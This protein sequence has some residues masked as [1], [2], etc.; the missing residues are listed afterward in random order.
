MKRFLSTTGI[1]IALVLLLTVSSCKNDP[2]VKI[3]LIE[4]ILIDDNSDQ[5][6]GLVSEHTDSMGME[7]NSSKQ[8]VSIVGYYSEYTLFYDGSG[9]LAKVEVIE[10]RL[11][12]V[13]YDYYIEFTW[14]GNTVTA[15]R[16]YAP[17]QPDYYK[18]VITF[19]SNDRMIK[20]EYFEEP[21][22]AAEW[23]LYGH[24]DYAWT[25]GNL[26]KLENYYDYAKSA[27]THSAPSF[28]MRDITRPSSEDPGKG[29]L[30][31][32]LSYMLEV[33]YDNKTNPFVNYPGLA[34]LFADE[35]PHVFLSKNN[36]LIVSG[37]EY[38]D[39]TYTWE[40]DYSYE[41]NDQGF[42]VV[43]E[44]SEDYGSFSRIETWTIKYQE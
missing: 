24:N 7:Y 33:T 32:T 31:G 40:V 26:T 11:A 28:S 20:M 43:I 41:F 38:G 19:D 22:K 34:L 17:N 21:N 35:M 29:Q 44:N 37:T 42:P 39:G 27:R 13:G 4:Y 14:S 30:A 3:P 6:K 1:V 18:S 25:N 5:F 2:E 8:L 10:Q 9:R 23:Y 15:Q 36:P 16:Y 12:K